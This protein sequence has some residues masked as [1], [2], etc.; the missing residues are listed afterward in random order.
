MAQQSNMQIFVKN[1]FFQATSK[2]FLIKTTWK[3]EAIYLHV[4]REWC[5]TDNDYYFVP[6]YVLFFVYVFACLFKKEREKP[7]L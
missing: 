5:E 4:L 6:L 7:S 2:L 1:A 3:G